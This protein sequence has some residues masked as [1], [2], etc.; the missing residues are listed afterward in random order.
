MPAILYILLSPAAI[1]FYIGH[2]TEPVRERPRKHLANHN[3]LTAKIKD[4]KV[5]YT[6]EYSARQLAYQRERKKNRKP[7]QDSTTY[8]KAHPVQRIRG[9]EPLRFVL[10][11]RS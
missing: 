4:W 5:V 11:N 10:A 2:T 8:Q 6:E 1:K 7:F 3:G 9:F